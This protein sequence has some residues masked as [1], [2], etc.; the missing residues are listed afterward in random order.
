MKTRWGAFLVILIVFLF[1]L[2]TARAE[3]IF[4]KDWQELEEGVAQKA[5][6]GEVIAMFQKG[7]ALAL[8]GEFE[9]AVE[10]FDRVSEHPDRREEGYIYRKEL[11]SDLEKTPED[12]ILLGKKAFLLFTDRDYDEALEILDKM[13]KQDPG[14]VWLDN[15]RALILVEQEEYSSAREILRSSLEKDENRYTR[16]FM[17]YAYWQEGK[18]GKAAS[19]FLRTGTLIFS[20]NKLLQ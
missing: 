7:V 6:A 19:H 9:D 13:E 14:N 17:G 3:S 15:Y 4:E 20:I 11:R 8:T 1:C 5:S 12:H 2:P 16:A 10:W 18:Y